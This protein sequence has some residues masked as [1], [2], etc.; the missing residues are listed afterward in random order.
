MKFRKVYTD[1]LRNSFATYFKKMLER[2][3]CQ[4]KYFYNGPLK[5][6]AQVIT[7]KGTNVNIQFPI[8][9]QNCLSTD[10]NG[11]IITSDK[12]SC[13]SNILDIPAIMNIF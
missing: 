11:F 10:Y 9:S 8:Y 13:M 3:E 2:S 12:K 1:S 7:K 6:E 5:I 4:I